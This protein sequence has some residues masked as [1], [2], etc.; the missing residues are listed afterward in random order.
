MRKTCF[1]HLP[2]CMI[3]TSRYLSAT[4]I[5]HLDYI[6]KFTSPNHPLNF[7][8]CFV[9]PLIKKMRN[10]VVVLYA[11]EESD[12]EINLFKGKDERSQDVMLLDDDVHAT[13]SRVISP[14]FDP[15]AMKRTFITKATGIP[16]HVMLLGNMQ[17][18]IASQTKFI[19]EMRSTINEEFDKRHMGSDS[20][21]AKNE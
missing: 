14:E 8:P 5:H 12:V 2:D 17:M 20:F 13:S 21:Q 1:P 7:L 4:L 6:Q 10:S 18:V 15:A 11:Y 19:H 9:S 3:S 16:P